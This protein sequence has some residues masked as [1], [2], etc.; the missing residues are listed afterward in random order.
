MRKQY[1]QFHAVDNSFKY[2]ASVVRRCL[3]VRLQHV[4][5][6][7]SSFSLGEKRRG[8]GTLVQTHGDSG[9]QQRSAGARDC[10]HDA[11]PCHAWYHH[12]PSKVVFFLSRPATQRASPSLDQVSLP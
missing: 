8:H 3:I 2:S 11:I 12:F 6:D 5:Q 1:S 4:R 7:C 10:S 9:A